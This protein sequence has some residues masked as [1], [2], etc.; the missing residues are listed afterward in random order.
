MLSR[1]AFLIF[2]FF[3]V[4]F[5]EL[6]YLFFGG[7]LDKTITLLQQPNELLASACNHFHIVIG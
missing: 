3:A 5:E 4:R 2:R 6:I 7:F 1:G